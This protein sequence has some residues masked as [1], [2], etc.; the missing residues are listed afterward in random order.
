[1]KFRNCPHCGKPMKQLNDS[2]CYCVNDK[3][4]ALKKGNMYRHCEL[5]EE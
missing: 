1:M 2:Y 5:I 4:P 3:C